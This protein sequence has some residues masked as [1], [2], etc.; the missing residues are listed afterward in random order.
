MVGLGEQDDEVFAVM[1]DLL[2]HGCSIMTIGQYLRP[3]RNQTPVVAHVSP[4][5]FNEYEKKGLALGFKTVFAGPYVRSSY[6]AEQLLN[7]TGSGCC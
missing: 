2:V 3:S 4:E 7:K 1:Q 5:K 6:M